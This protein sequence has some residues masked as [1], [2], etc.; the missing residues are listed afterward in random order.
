MPA[1][2]EGLRML[3]VAQSAEVARR[4]HAQLSGTAS[5]HTVRH[6]PNCTQAERLLRAATSTLADVPS[7]PEQAVDVL[8]LDPRLGD[9][10]GVEA[11]ERLRR[12]APSIPIVVVSHGRGHGFDD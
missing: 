5:A 10:S 3:V 2:R 12:V 8:L 9:A 11:L 4:L 7:T 1:A 6:V